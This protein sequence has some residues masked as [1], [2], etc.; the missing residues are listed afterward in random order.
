MEVVLDAFA[1]KLRW[2]G[3]C[4][5][6][7]RAKGVREGRECF[8]YGMVEGTRPDDNSVEVIEAGTRTAAGIAKSDLRTL[9]RGNRRVVRAE[10]GRFR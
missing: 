4:K 10:S 6:S 8:V 5:R 1:G 2:D 9:G 3:G 7:R